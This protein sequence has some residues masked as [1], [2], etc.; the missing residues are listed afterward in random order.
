MKTDK[1]LTY[2]TFRAVLLKSTGIK[3][4]QVAGGAGEDGGKKSL[5][6]FCFT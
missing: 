6:I 4:T 3:K 5:V 1:E 2:N